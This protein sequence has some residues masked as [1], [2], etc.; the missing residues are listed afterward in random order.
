MCLPTP[1]SWFS[2]S[3]L[4]SIYVKN[5]FVIL[6]SMAMNLY[7]TLGMWSFYINLPIHEHVMSFHLF[8]SALAVF[9]SFQYT[10]L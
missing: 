9:D 6:I 1:P 10:N 4:F 8:M 3:E 5:V 7:I 2:H